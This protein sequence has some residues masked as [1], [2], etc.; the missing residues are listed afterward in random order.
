MS[1]KIRH[2]QDNA[3]VFLLTYP[4]YPLLFYFSHTMTDADPDS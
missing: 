1:A 4:T 3:A 2:T